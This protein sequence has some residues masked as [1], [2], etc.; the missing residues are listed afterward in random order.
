MSKGL[1]LR[2]LEE[3]S[4]ISNVLISRYEMGKASPPIKTIG[5]LA[6]GLGVSIEELRSENDDTQFFDEKKF[7][8]KLE[9]ALKLGTN[10]K[11]VIEGVLDSFIKN[12]EIQN[13][14]NKL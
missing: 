10:D 8:S 13:L 12:W 14:A 5:M 11:K 9:K 6:D 1:S 7:K 4:S 3:K 2:D